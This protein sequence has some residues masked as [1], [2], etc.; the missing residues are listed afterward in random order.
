[1]VHEYALEPSLLSNWRDMRYFTEKFGFSQGRLISR[2]PKRWKRMV[3]ECLEGQGLLPIE[4][5]RCVECLNLLTDKMLKRPGL[6]YEPGKE[7]LANAVNEHHRKQFHAIVAR[8]GLQGHDFVLDGGSLDETRPLWRVRTGI[9]VPRDKPEEVADRLVPILETAEEF[10]FVDPHF[11]FENPRHRMFMEPLLTH[12]FSRHDFPLPARIEVH[13]EAKAEQG[14]FRG[15]CKQWLEPILPAGMAVQ[16]SR[17]QERKPGEKLHN[18]YIFTERGGFGVSVGLDTG[19]PGQ[20]DD[21]FLLDHDL[22][23]SRREQYCGSDPAFDLV[24]GL[25]VTGVSA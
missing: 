1:M 25:T 4:Q 12:A 10:I 6:K 23:L 2:Y 17:W 11:G 7:W 24:D 22:Y 9:Q 21:I 8:E 18:R 13:V 5:A 15:R 19:E 14:F 16:F 3:H 20:T